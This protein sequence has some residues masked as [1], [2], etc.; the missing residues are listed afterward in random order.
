M[1][2]PKFFPVRELKLKYLSH[3]RTQWIEEL[4]LKFRKKANRRTRKGTKVQKH[5]KCKM[6]WGWGT[7]GYICLPYVTILWCLRW[8]LPKYRGKMKLILLASK[9]LSRLWNPGSP[10]FLNLDYNQWLKWINLAFGNLD[11]LKKSSK[12]VPSK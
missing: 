8:K 3:K 4:K 12:V 5:K 2:F 10:L 1:R 11:I 9:E 7:N 6:A